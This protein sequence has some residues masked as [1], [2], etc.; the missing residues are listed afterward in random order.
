MNAIYA[1]TH[2]HAHGS[3]NE[4]SCSISAPALQC[5]RV[6]Q[7]RIVGL[8]PEGVRPIARRDRDVL[9]RG[10]SVDVPKKID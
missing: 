4:L 5:G 3:E 9:P 7:T 1:F 2:D 10:L 8:L 6:G